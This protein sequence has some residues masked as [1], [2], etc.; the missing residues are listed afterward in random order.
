MYDTSLLLALCSVPTVCVVFA[1]GYMVGTGVYCRR[2]M[3]ETKSVTP[4]ADSWK[5]LKPR[6]TSSSKAHFVDST[7][8]SSAAVVTTLDG[9]QYD[10]A[11]VNRNGTGLRGS[12]CDLT[13]DMSALIQIAGRRQAVWLRK[14]AARENP[15]AKKDA[16]HIPQKRTITRSM[17]TEPRVAA[18]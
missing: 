18:T 9:A 12:T 10:V 1:F 17:P 11:G 7:I 8:R 5:V 4:P 2:S 14:R 6:L 16:Q 3:G 15:V 13:Q